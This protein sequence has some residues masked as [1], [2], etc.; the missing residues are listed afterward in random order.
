M[1]MCKQHQRIGWRGKTPEEIL[2]HLLGG[3]NNFKT[4]TYLSMSGT[5]EIWILCSIVS[6]LLAWLIKEKYI[7]I[8]WEGWFLLDLS[9]K[10]ICGFS[11]Y[12]TSK[13]RHNRQNTWYN[14]EISAQWSWMYLTSNELIEN[15]EE[16][17]DH[18]IIYR[19]NVNQR[20]IFVFRWLLFFRP[21]L[22]WTA[23][24][25]NRTRTN[26]HVSTGTVY[27]WTSWWRDTLKDTQRH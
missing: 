13:G 20:D 12:L 14:V 4:G 10:W 1:H 3:S 18:N 17:K 5:S 9:E 8:L 27:R 19:N 16:Q 15:E 11:V 24:P 23:Q 26:T 22:D 6:L 7:C 2:E 25:K 21:R